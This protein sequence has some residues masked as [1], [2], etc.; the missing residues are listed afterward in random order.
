M[1]LLPLALFSSAV[2]LSYARLV[3]VLGAG[4]TAA[5]G[6]TIARF[7][8][9]FLACLIYLTSTRSSRSTLL[10]SSSPTG[11]RHHR[12]LVLR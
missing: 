6:V 5:D 8:V 2:L 10:P 11:R 12:T 4:R 1:S 3:V 7:A 9:Y